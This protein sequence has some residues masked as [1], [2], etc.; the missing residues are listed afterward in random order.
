M[1]V[2]MAEIDHEAAHEAAWRHVNKYPDDAAISLVARAYLA[3][4]SRPPCRK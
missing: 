4:A 1:T 3:R 2:V